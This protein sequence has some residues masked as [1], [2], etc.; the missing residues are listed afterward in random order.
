M[1]EEVT[2]VMYNKRMEYDEMM[3][4][5][6][7]KRKAKIEFENNSILKKQVVL[8]YKNVKKNIKQAWRKL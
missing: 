5:A 7:M 2:E 8:N 1:W 4:L 6:K 3:F